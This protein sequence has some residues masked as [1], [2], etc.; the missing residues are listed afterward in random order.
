MVSERPDQYES[1]HRLAEIER[2]T[3]RSGDLQRSLA[4]IRAGTALVEEGDDTPFVRSTAAYRRDS[5][6]P[7]DPS[8]DITKIAWA[9]ERLDINKFTAYRLAEQGLLPGAFK[10][11]RQW[12][13]SVPRFERE[14]HRSVEKE[15]G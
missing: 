9:A 6:A 7:A 4:I 12:R 15:D 8:E 14:V 2:A 1:A 13:I 5:S 11:G 3:P 10:V